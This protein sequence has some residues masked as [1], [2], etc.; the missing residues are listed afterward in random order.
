MT[1]PRAGADAAGVQEDPGAPSRGELAGAR[2][3]GLGD[4]TCP[5]QADAPGPKARRARRS[6]HRPIPGRPRRRG[7]VATL[8]G[9]G[10]GGVPRCAGYA[11]PTTHMASG[12][13]KTQLSGW[14][15]Q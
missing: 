8:Q 5:A 14:A 2:A 4:P 11:A 1:A 9:N 15:A 6:R 13:Q 10:G 3:A 12:L 7:G